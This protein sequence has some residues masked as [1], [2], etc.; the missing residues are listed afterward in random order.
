MKPHARTDV[1][2]GGAGFAGLALAIA[3]RQGLGD[4]LRGDGR[5]S[6]AGAR[7]V[8]GPARLARSPPRRAGCSR[9]SGSGSGRARRAADPRHGGDRLQ[10]RGR[11]AADFSHLR[12]RSRGGRAVRAHDREPASGRRAGGE[13]KG[14]RRRS[15]RRRGRPALTRCRAPST[16]TLDR[17]RD[18]FRAAAGRRR[19]RA[20]GDPRAGRHRHA[21]LGL[22]P[23]GD[24][25]HGRA[26][27]RSQWP[28]RRAFPAGRAVRDPAADR[29]TLVD[30]VDRRQRARPSASSR[31]RT[32]NFT[33]SLKSASACSSATSRSSARAAPFRSGCS[34]R[35]AFIAERLALIG[36]AAHIIHPI[37]GQGLNMGLR[38]VAALAEAI[39]DA[40]RLGLD[41]GAAG[42]AG[43]LSALAALRHHD[44]GRRDRRVEPA[45][46]QPLRR[47]A[48]G[49]R[50]R[51][52]PGRAHA[53]RSSACSSARR[54]ALPATCR[55]CCA[56]RRFNI[57]RPAAAGSHS[58]SVSKSRLWVPAFGDDRSSRQRNAA[59]VILERLAR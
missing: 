24:R 8:E 16:S 56:A 20:F 38:D 51:P 52:R 34:P 29:E 22:R 28:R 37:A 25:H 43:A 36:D 26:R 6:G 59:D 50:R 48:A 30:R 31:C 47:A 21:R 41:I 46:L 35:A 5:R 54:P 12:R 58:Q 14:A 32:T 11:G 27:A 4:S 2:I 53:R 7:A 13:G 9:Q 39:A 17:R 1:V 55:S 3:L 23:V 44:H 19:R 15:A 40:A 45:V 18:D 33:P 49:A 42:R 10:A 57:C